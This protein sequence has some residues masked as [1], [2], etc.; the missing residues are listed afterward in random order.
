MV[1]HVSKRYKSLRDR[2]IAQTGSCCLAG[3]RAR[4]ANLTNEGAAAHFNVTPRTIQAW[5][6]LAKDPDMWCTEHLKTLAPGVPLPRE[7][8]TQDEVPLAQVLRLRL[9]ALSTGE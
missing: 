5:R 2:V 9:S 8:E 3:F 4:Y 6:T 1:F 7:D